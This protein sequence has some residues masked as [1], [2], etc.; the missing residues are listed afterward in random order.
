VAAHECPHVTAT[1]VPH[2]DE[3][4][5]VRFAS[6]EYRDDVR[7]IYRRCGARL[8]DESF[9]E[10]LVGSGDRRQDLHRDSAAQPFVS[11]TKDYGHP[12]LADLLLQ[13]VA[14]DPVPHTDSSGHQEVGVP[15]KPPGAHQTPPIC[16][17]VAALAGA[18]DMIAISKRSISYR[19]I[20]YL[21]GSVQAQRVNVSLGP[22]R[23]SSSMCQ[24][25]APAATPRLASYH[26]E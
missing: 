4:H 21:A 16:R 10:C 3:E 15:A 22:R 1:D 26:D 19:A 11:S 2:R 9:P 7:V 18:G 6:F 24:I 13:L 25:C 23:R 5:A 20:K 14:R 12:A 17:Q 8:S